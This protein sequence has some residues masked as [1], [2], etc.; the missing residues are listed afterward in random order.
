MTNPNQQQ[1][2]YWN[3]AAGE[4]WALL[5][6]RIDLNLNDITDALLEFANAQ[7]GERIIDIGCGCGT[8][9]LRLG[10]CAG[11]EGMAAGIDISAPM[12]NVARARA[13]AMMADIAFV[14]ADASAYEFQP[15]NDLVFSRFGVMFFAD[16]TAAFANLRNALTRKGRLVFACW[17]SLPE[18]LWAAAP[19]ASA[20]D[21]LPPQEPV[22][23]HAPGPFAFADAE[24]LRG[25]LERAGYSNIRIEKLDTVM[26]MGSTLDNAVASSLDIGPL[27]RVAAELDETTKKKIKERVR[28][29]LA[30]FVSPRGVTPPAACWLGQAKN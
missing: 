21:L 12:L 8:T 1:I 28:Q 6:E 30:K 4:K 22:D 15:L 13:Q 27:G 11:R 26:N 24:R 5:Q 25:I 7:A 9:T 2:D 18:N 16:P 17:R 19:F 10:M 20:R 29:A 3:G 14:E 23:P